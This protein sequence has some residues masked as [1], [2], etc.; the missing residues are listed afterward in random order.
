ME[1]RA[2]DLRHLTE[3]AR[4]NIE[5]RI[6]LRSFSSY[7][8]WMKTA[9]DLEKHVML[10]LNAA[11][12]YDEQLGWIERKDPF[13]AETRPTRLRMRLPSEFG[14]RGNPLNHA[15]L[16][17]LMK[18]ALNAQ[19]TLPKLLP[20]GLQ[21]EEQADQ[22]DALTIVTPDKGQI[23][24]LSAGFGKL[25]EKLVERTEE[26]RIERGL[27]VFGEKIEEP[28][29]LDAPGR[30]ML[31]LDNERP[32]ADDEEWETVTITVDDDLPEGVYRNEEGEILPIGMAGG[33]E[34][35]EWDSGGDD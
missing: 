24:E 8:N 4:E 6:L 15:N 5:E 33:D 29:P 18:V 14:G 17:R 21:L 20:P 12:V 11:E 31:E 30:D 32:L 7:Q 35:G 1:K 19:L 34:D 23:A 28:P 2:E 27:N 10:F 13:D 9:D 16:E 26:R 3:R 25:V 22:R